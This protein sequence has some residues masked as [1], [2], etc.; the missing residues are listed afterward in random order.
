MSF[1]AIKQIDGYGRTT[2][3]RREVKPFGTLSDYYSA[4]A[5]L[6]TNFL[7]V[8]DLGLVKVTLNLDMGQAPTDPAIATAN[9]DVGGTF[10][11]QT[12]S[13]LPKVATLKTPG[14]KMTFVQP[15][16]SIDL[17]NLTILSYLNQ[18]LET[19]ALRISDGESITGWLRGRL[20]K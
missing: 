3:R 2:T 17:T 6:R 20:D 19:G 14:L 1:F 9:I 4:A 7:A 12:D 5:T 15:G 8:S 11:G 13:P 18:Y 16:G 10:A